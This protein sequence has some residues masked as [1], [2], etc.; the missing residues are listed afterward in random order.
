MKNIAMLLMVVT[1]FCAGNLAVSAAERPQRVKAAATPVAAPA[2]VAVPA[3]LSIIPAQAEPGSK[4][5]LFGSGFGTQASAYLGS[6]EIP[7]RVVDGRQVEFSIPQQFAPGLYALYLKRSDGAASRPYNF[8]ILPQRPVLNGLSPDVISSCTQ[9]AEREVTA[10]GH[11][12]L[13]TSQLVFD[14]A[15]LKSRFA[16]AEALT[17]RVPN[18]AGGLHQVVVRNSSENSSVALG[19]MIETKPEIVQVMIGSQYVNYYELEI[20]GKNFQQNSS[21]YVDGQKIGGSQD[22]AERE[23]LIYVDCTR[24]VYQR[25]PFSPVNKDFRIMVMN[26]GGEASQIINVTAP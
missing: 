2:G 13:E 19:L 24:L 15:V 4:V 12:F 18:V 22:L 25:H 17:F 11:N 23:K 20:V 10:R 5:V 16:S 26:P 7:A 8:T 14:G 6:V 21:V 9:G 3:I 1:F